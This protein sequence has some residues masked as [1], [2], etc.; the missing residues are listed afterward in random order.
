MAAA[1]F[2]LTLQLHEEMPRMKRRESSL[3]AIAEAEAKGGPSFRVHS[4]WR[5]VAVNLGGV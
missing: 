1:E 5:K 3:M 2:F 4:F